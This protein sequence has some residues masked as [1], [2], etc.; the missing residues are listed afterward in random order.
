MFCKRGQFPSQ[1]ES[2]PLYVALRSRS[3]LSL[4][5]HLVTAGL[6]GF[7][8][9]VSVMSI[10][11]SSLMLFVPVLYEK[12]DKLAR[13]ERA[14]REVRVG[15]ILNGVGTVLNLLIAYVFTAHPSSRLHI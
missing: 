8:V 7:A 3:P 4:T 15:F 6:S 5:H 14:L 10:V 2:W 12:Y 13:I 1:V 9:F 11:L